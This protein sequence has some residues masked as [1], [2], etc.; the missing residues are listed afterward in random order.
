MKPR[1]RGILGVIRETFRSW[2]EDKA[3]RLAAALSYYT[4]FSLAPLL[5]LVIAITSFIIGSNEVVRE[6]VLVEVRGLV[7]AQGAEM[8]DTLITN[9]SRPREGLLATVIG[10]VALF[11]G[12]TG[13]FA[14]LKDALNTIWEVAPRN[15]LGIGWIVRERLSGFVMIL[16]LGFL[17]LV[18]LVISTALSVLN[19]YFTNQL[20]DTGWVSLVLNYAI[21][22][23]VITFI[24]GSIFRFVPDV[25]IRWSDVWVGGFVTAVLFL[26]GQYLISLYLSR[27]SPASA[28]GAAGSLVILFLWV[29]YSAQILFLG[30]E[31]TRAYSYSRRARIMPNENARPLT[32]EERI[33]QGI[34]HEEE[35]AQVEERPGVAVGMAAPIPVSGEAEERKETVD[36]DDEAEKRRL[37]RVDEP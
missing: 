3:P 11:I 10:I 19:S 14:Q 9:T 22:V 32:A 34:V 28:Y 30:A 23:V 37:H 17:L 13:V 20:G 16:G 24:F 29:Y 31:F 33:H 1:P 21:Q 4:I 7:G 8:V 35:E 6:R 15:N 25:K 12:A 18:S 26:A 5:V 36:E 27:A 2:G